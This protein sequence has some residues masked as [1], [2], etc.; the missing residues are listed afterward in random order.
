MSCVRSAMKLAAGVCLQ[1]WEYS[2]AY[3]FVDKRVGET[4]APEGWCT[5]IMYAFR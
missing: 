2:H 4:A 3:L 5:P 1:C